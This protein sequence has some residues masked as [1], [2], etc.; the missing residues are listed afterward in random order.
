MFIFRVIL[1]E[2][3]KYTQKKKFKTLA[4]RE[5]PKFS[6][7]DSSGEAAVPSEHEKLMVGTPF[8][9]ITILLDAFIFFFFLED[10]SF[11]GILY[12]VTPLYL[13]TY[14]RILCYKHVSTNLK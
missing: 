11:C 12:R 7:N 3:F 1:T 5:Y 4:S 13:Y 10:A 2:S 8:Q 6:R 9:R 14:T